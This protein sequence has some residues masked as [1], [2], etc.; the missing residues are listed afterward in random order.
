MTT[1]V[2]TCIVIL[3]VNVKMCLKKGKHSKFALQEII[4]FPKFMQS[5]RETGL[6]NSFS[7]SNYYS[8]RLN[9]VRFGCPYELIFLMFVKALIFD[10]FVLTIDITS[11]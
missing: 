9:Y 3:L 2:D 1:I 8:Q 4:G 7:N 11:V 6:T 10:L 5:N